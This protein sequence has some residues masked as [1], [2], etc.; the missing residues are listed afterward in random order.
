MKKINLF[1]IVFVLL[2]LIMQ[3]VPVPWK[4]SYDERWFAGKGSSL[5]I[6]H[7][8]GRENWPENTG[9]AFSEAVKAGADIL[10]MDVQLSRDGIPLVLHDR[11]YKDAEHGST[12]EHRGISRT[13]FCPPLNRISGKPFDLTKDISSYTLAELGQCSFA[14]D[15][16]FRKRKDFQRMIPCDIKDKRYEEIY[17][18]F[19]K[20]SDFHPEQIKPLAE[21]RSFLDAK[22][23]FDN[24]DQNSS[25]RIAIAR[26][27]E[28]VFQ[29]FQNNGV[30]F[31]IEIKQPG[32]MGREA[33]DKVLALARKYKMDHRILLQTFH[34]DIAK[35]LEQV[36]RGKARIGP[37]VAAT[38]EMLLSF[39]IGSD[40]FL[41]TEFA[42]FSLPAGTSIPPRDR[43]PVALDNKFL[44]WKAHRHNIPVYF[45]TV[46]K[47]EEMLALIRLGA[48]GIITDDPLLLLKLNAKGRKK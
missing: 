43:P 8:G 29:S 20:H 16:V 26:L 4:R 23:C 47:K 42:S 7:R 3:I 39:V 37:G 9:L 21:I 27:E 2:Y 34:D 10:E 1:I 15:H 35:Y 13:A 12:N 40:F 48:D 38:K 44:L 11:N 33:T 18:K 17:Q 32:K 41:Q 24:R 31:L 6:A 5:V 19:L 36:E 25:N 28:D 22:N 45:W 46:N 14:K 30:L